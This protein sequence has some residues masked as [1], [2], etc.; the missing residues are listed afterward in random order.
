MNSPPA[1]RDIMTWNSRLYGLAAPFIFVWLTISQLSAAPL[2]SNV[3]TQQWNDGSRLVDV[4]YDL[5]AG[6][7]S[8]EVHVVFSKDDGQ[9]WNLIPTKAA[10]SGDVSKG[11]VNGDKKHIVWNPM[12]DE[13]EVGLP[14]IKAN[15]IAVD[16]AAGTTVAVNLPGAVELQMV[17][18]LAGRF[19]MGSPKSER[20]RSD[21]EG[22]VHSVALPY[23]FYIG[24]FEVTQAQWQSVMSNNPAKVYGMGDDYPVFYVSWDDCQAFVAALNRLGQGL[25]RLPSEA[26]WEYACRAGSTERYYFGDSLNIADAC[27]NGDAGKLPGNRTDYMW[28]C[29]SGPSEPD[30][31][32]GTAPVGGR[33]PN[34]FGLHD[35]SGNVWEWCLDEYHS[36]YRGAP[37]N[38]SAW[39]DK[40]GAPRVLRGGGWGYHA[41]HCRSASRAGY[42]PGRRYTFHGLRLVWFPYARESDA[43]FASWDATA[44]ADNIVSYQSKL[45]GWPK[46]TDMITHGYQGEK[47]TKNW[48]A[49]IDN[50]ATFTQM[51]FLARAYHATGHPRFEASFNRGLDFLLK[52]QHDSGGWPQRYPLC[53]DYGDHIVFN[54]GAMVGVMRLLRNIERRPEFSFVDAKR[55]KLAKA[56]YE[57]GLKCM[58]DCQIKVGGQRT[59]WGGHHDAKTLAPRRGRIYEAP[60]ICGRET[61]SILAFLMSLEKPS[62]ETIEA[63]EA[64]VAWYKRNEL[65]AIRLERQGGDVVVVPDPT[66]PPQW[67]R[68]YDPETGRPIF[69]GHDGV[70]HHSLAEIDKERRLGYG[71]YTRA[72]EEAI[73][74]FPFWKARQKLS[75]S[76]SH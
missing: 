22:P 39:I 74:E 23:D 34:A 18:I 4:L 1:E 43:W 73:L 56:A 20:G 76:K 26:E 63:I 25:F 51:E 52:A 8:M 55:R 10:L 36:D 72:G 67:A 69:C 37:N 49:T 2:V 58:L 75:K 29:G 14:R 11:V 28:Y 3:L 5:S 48:E 30:P 27:E 45:G 24:K 33:K 19:R 54:D 71:W 42:T 16:T 53:G 7:N 59:G 32:F 21:D 66:A 68:F 57:K 13:V 47:F 61:A 12:I 65:P 40:A 64:G 38:G 60:G 41:R 35:M 62:P 15:V 46:N 9:T 70:I 50:S 17:R 31:D 44:N 6:G